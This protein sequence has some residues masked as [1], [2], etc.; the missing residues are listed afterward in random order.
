[1]K[2]LFFLV[3]PNREDKDESF[4]CVC[5]LKSGDNDIIYETFSC[6]ILL[7]TWVVLISY[8]LL[9]NTKQTF[10]ENESAV[11][12]CLSNVCFKFCLNVVFSIT[13]HNNN[14]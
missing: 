2:R 11:F 13:G 10:Q 5:L 12:F 9:I 14:N 6:H 8:L 1:M 4:L 3:N 7:Q